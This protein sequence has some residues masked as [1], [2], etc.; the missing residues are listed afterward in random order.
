M[1]LCG[2]PK[3]PL[4][5]FL[6]KFERRQQHAIH[7]NDLKKEFF[8]K[9]VSDY[10]DVEGD[11]QK[12]VEIFNDIEKVEEGQKLTLGYLTK[13]NFLILMHNINDNGKLIPHMRFIIDEV[14]LSFHHSVIISRF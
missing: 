14:N 6:Q 2:A 13:Y 11:E 7:Y 9:H 8:Y 5:F 1:T 4:F 3:Q 10:V 12:I